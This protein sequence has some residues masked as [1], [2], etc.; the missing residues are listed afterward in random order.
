MVYRTPSWQ[1]LSIQ[2]A[3]PSWHTRQIRY[4]LSSVKVSLPVSKSRERK[5]QLLN[6]PLKL[7]MES[8]AFSGQGRVVN[9]KR[10][11]KPKLPT[12]L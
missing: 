4:L 12:I 5:T 9:E 2:L 11:I 1:S 6:Q 8:Q 3:L 7:L 10:H